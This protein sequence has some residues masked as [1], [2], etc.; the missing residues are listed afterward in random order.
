[1]PRPNPEPRTRTSNSEPG[2]QEPGTRYQEPGTRN[3]EPGTGQP[4]LV[5]GCPDSAPRL[6]PDSFDFVP[7]NPGRREDNAL[8]QPVAAADLHLGRRD[9]QHLDHD[10]VLRAGVVGIDH[11]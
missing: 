8:S 3:Q 1:M 11:A 6:V 4:V 5:S 2:N 7:M 10:F 9:V